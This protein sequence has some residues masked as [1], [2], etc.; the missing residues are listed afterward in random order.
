M[1]V[2]AVAKFVA[3]IEREGVHSILRSREP[4]LRDKCWVIIQNSS[5][6]L[7][8]KPISGKGDCRLRLRSIQFGHIPYSISAMQ[9]QAS[10][11]SNLVAA[12]HRQSI[13]AG[14]SRKRDPE[15]VL[16][17]PACQRGSA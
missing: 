11:L 15:R 3:T 17:A 5:S 4:F 6:Q 1:H 10:R 14:Q 16:A 12:L 7:I 8:C 13:Y 9:F 2:A